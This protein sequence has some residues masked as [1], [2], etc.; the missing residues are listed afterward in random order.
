MEAN[1]AIIAFKQLQ[2]EKGD[3]ACVSCPTPAAAAAAAAY[4]AAAAAVAVA[5][6][7]G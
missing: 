5:Y 7:G 1:A 2:T 4:T 6:F 3:V